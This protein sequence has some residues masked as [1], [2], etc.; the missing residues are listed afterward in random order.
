MRESLSCRAWH[1]FIAGDV[2]HAHA[3]AHAATVTRPGTRRDRQR[4]QIVELAITGQL[5]RAAGL[6]A[7][8]LAEF[9]ADQMIRQ[10]R[11]WA[12]RHQPDAT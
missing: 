11:D 1:A 5:H 4:A 9:P 8:H 7:E 10:V 12:S 3:L 2:T 6:A